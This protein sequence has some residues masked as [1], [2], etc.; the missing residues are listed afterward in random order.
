[1]DKEK[2]LS[3]GDTAESPQ[4]DSREDI[5]WVNSPYKYYTPDSPL[6]Q[7]AEPDFSRGAEWKQT[8][9]GKN[10]IYL[11]GQPFGEETEN[12]VVAKNRYISAMS[13]SITRRVKHYCRETGRN[14]LMGCR[15]NLPCMICRELGRDT[16]ENGCICRE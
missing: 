11:W 14:E 2:G 8:P 6:C 4:E 7:G 15:V 16:K 12:P 1:M 9:D 10:Q 13:A 3:P 5:I